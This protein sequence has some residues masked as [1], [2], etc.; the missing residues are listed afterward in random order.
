MLQR[1]QSI[2]LFL[3]ALASFAGI[4]LPFYAYIGT[5]PVGIPSPA[6]HAVDVTVLL[7]A[8]VIVGTITLLTIFLFRNR[9]LQLKLSLVALVVQCI[10]LYL[11]YFESRKYQPGTYTLWSILQPLIIIFIVLAILGIRRDEK[12]IKESNR[13]R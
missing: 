3:A 7:I 10:L 4:A 1:I 12:I 13:L 9:P 6:L 8:S 2:W 5:N 11:Y